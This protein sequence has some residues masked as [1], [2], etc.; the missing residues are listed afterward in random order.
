MIMLT[1]A[2]AQV[3]VQDLIYHYPLLS[4]IAS[5]ESHI[6]LKGLI[7]IYRSTSDFTLDR[8]YMIEINV[9]VGSPNLPTVIDS[10]GAIDS[11]YPHRYKSGELCLETSTAIHMRFIDGM[12]LVQWV[13]EFVEPYFF[14][15][16]YYTR[17]G[18]LPFGERPHGLEG[19][20]NTYQDI[21]H[22][23]DTGKA[24]ALLRYCADESYRGHINCPCGSNQ[25][26]RKCHGPFVFPIMND[27]RKK[28]IARKDIEA[29]RKELAA[30]ES[31]RKN[32]RTAKQVGNA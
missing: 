9:P 10:G 13:E 22:E 20:I 24:I 12:N 28:E 2:S 23:P 21:F 1:V 32:K 19:I 26:L 15:Y 25:K 18:I 7:D 4:V 29:L 3:Q 31:A 17:F 14:S 8:S 5:D 6:Q 16:E 27:P 11:S 30:Y